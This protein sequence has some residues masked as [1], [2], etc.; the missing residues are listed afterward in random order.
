MKKTIRIGTRKSDLAVIQA[1][2]VACEL[3]RVAPEIRTELVY[4]M[5]EGDRIIDKPLLSFGGKG[6]FVTEFEEALQRGEIDFAVHSAK[7]LPV[8]LGEG[9]T[10]A[11]VLI[12]EDARDVLVTLSGR[13]LSGKKTIVTGTS[14]LRRKAQLKGGKI[15]NLPWDQD[16][17]IRC[18]DLRGNVLTRLKKLEAGEYDCEVL[19]AAGLKRLGLLDDERYQFTFLDCEQFIPAG[20]QGILAVEG[21]EGDVLC[22]LANRITHRE[23]WISLGFERRVLEILKAGCHEPVGVYSRI[24][25][26]TLCAWGVYSS[27]EVDKI[28]GAG[29]VV[30]VEGP[31]D[32]WELLAEELV[33]LLMRKSD[34]LVCLV[35]AGPGDPGLITL[36]GA[37]RLR[38]C[39]TVVYDYLSNDGL[40]E[41]VKPECQRIYVGKKAGDH[42]VSQD[43]INRLL[44][45]HGKEGRMVVRLKGGD[46]YVFGRGGEEA[47]ALKEAGIPYEVIPGVTSAV[48]ALSS[49]GI[50]V[51]H[52]GLSRSFHVMTGHTQDGQEKGGL[53]EDFPEFAK[54]SGTLVFLMGL[55]NLSLIVEG[56]V[57]SGKAKSTPA[58]VVE[59]GTMPDQRVI[60]GTLET[61]EELVRKAR[62]K[63]PAIIVAGDTAALDFR[64][65]S[66]L[67]LAGIRFG[68]TGTGQFRDKL[69]GQL[70]RLGAVT[71]AL[72]RMDLCSYGKSEAVQRELHNLGYYTWLV[73]TSAN[74][75]RIFFQELLEAGLDHRD[76]GKLQIAAVGS[77]TAEE[78]KSYGFIAD[79]IPDCFCTESLANGLAKLLHESDRVLIPRS[80]GGSRILNQ[81][82]D[83]VGIIYCD[84]GLYEVLGEKKDSKIWAEQ[85]RNLDYLVFGSASGVDGVFASMAPRERQQ[86]SA[87]TACIGRFTA[88][89]LKH[90]GFHA[91]C[92]AETYDIAGLVEC[93]CQTIKHKPTGGYQHE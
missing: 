54:Q 76:L 15:P 31:V 34:G 83:Q 18:E 43:E 27:S 21:R 73:F 20:G 91:E 92:V 88:N 36:K 7:D 93:I 8:D 78:L 24:Q 72:C 17:L 38:Q 62:M 50:P 51:T 46:P 28:W 70:E 3:E 4:K 32:Q 14:S 75:V 56:L 45:Q 37:A 22:D 67:P 25:G 69:S 87:G 52:R 85:I 63:S 16:A 40:L 77:G 59:R 60:R 90:Y 58:A 6:V 89:R 1:K 39:D 68:L 44:V 19:A 5:T 48:A 55:G 9:L 80:S 81:V 2:L 49:A 29:S 86:I 71:A 57:T 65:E 82:F 11:G 53:P 13:E 84:L 10:I 35:G 47:Q 33:K 74:G 41:Y 26:E 66:V 23:S 61:I 79:Y 42:S 30:R 64:S 12:R